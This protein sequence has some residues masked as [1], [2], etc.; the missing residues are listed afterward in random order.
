MKTKQSSKWYFRIPPTIVILFVV[1][2]YNVSKLL[3]KK[4]TIKS[5][6]DY[7]TMCKG[8]TRDIKD[9]RLDECFIN[10]ELMSPYEAI[11]YS[12]KCPKGKCKHDK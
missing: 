1:I 5:K 6:I 4:K 10:G 9:L 7:S 3:S 8:C 11:M 12:A 2:V